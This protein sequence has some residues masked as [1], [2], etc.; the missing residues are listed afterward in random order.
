MLR[1]HYICCSLCFSS[2][3]LCLAG[4]CTC[5]A[6]VADCRH[7]NMSDFPLLQ[8]SETRTLRTILFDFNNINITVDTLGGFHWLGRLR[9]SN[10]HIRKIPEFAFKDLANLF[11]LDLSSNSIETLDSGVTF[12][13]LASLLRLDLSNNRIKSLTFDTFVGAEGIVHLILERNPIINVD[14]RAFDILV[15]LR[16]LNT[17]AYKFCC[18][19]DQA[20]TCTPEADEFSSCEDLMANYPLQ[21]SIWALGFSALV[22]NLF[23]VAWRAYRNDR[24][25]S[26]FLILNLHIS[27]LLM[28]I[29][30]IIIAS[31]DVHYRG[32]FTF[33][34]K[35]SVDILSILH[36]V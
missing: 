15:S 5:D 9:L 11:E 30:M 13:G 18:I 33:P 4:S 23:S 28:G 36:K 34:L 25:T 24:K 3:P 17:D 2:D 22:G 1:I 20:E 12:V 16:R 31:V 14:Q 7:G 6:F 21:I 26:S 32:K 27:D 8:Q 29:Y 19:A 35:R 10:N